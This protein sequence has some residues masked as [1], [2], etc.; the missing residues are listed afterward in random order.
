MIGIWW[1]SNWYCNSTAGGNQARN[2]KP[3]WDPW[4]TIC[5]T[6]WYSPEVAQLAPSLTWRKNPKTHYL[7]FNEVPGPSVYHLWNGFPIPLP[8]SSLE[9]CS[10]Q[11]LPRMPGIGQQTTWMRRKRK[12]FRFSMV[13]MQ[14]HE[15]DH[16]APPRR[17][18]CH[19]LFKCFMRHRN[20]NLLWEVCVLIHA[21]TRKSA[22]TLYIQQNGLCTWDAWA[23]D[24]QP[25][26]ALIW[27]WYPFNLMREIFPDWF[28]LSSVMAYFPAS[29]TTTSFSKVIL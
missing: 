15:V 1:A 27:I 28:Y 23:R 17:G 16:V 9:L 26:S 4:S 13:V 6:D 29:F 7:L 11:Y 20:A 21:I 10:I 3:L 2:A 24:M 12:I 5:H 19:G 14:K 18:E 8:S 25:E 22:F